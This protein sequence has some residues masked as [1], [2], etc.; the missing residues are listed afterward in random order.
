M[1]TVA[2]EQ[3]VVRR[4]RWSAHLW[5]LPL[6]LLAIILLGPVL[7]MVSTSL[8]QPGTEFAYPPVPLPQ[9]VVWRNYLDA[10]AQQPFGR[11]LANTLIIAG[12][13]TLGTVVSASLAAF[14]FA[15]IRFPGRDL[16]FVLLL[17]T[18]MLPDVVTLVPRY[19]LFS[20][21]HWINTFLPLTVPPW[22]GGGA[23]NVFLIRQF[24]MG[25]PYELDEAARM[26]GANNLQIYRQILLP[27]AGPALA[28]VAIFTVVANWNDF[29]SPLIYLNTP[30]R[31]TL[32]LGLQNYQTLYG[33]Q[34]AWLMAAA[35]VMVAPVVALFFAFQRFFV[36]GI[37]VTGLAGR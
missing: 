25:I 7:W 13:T 1:S 6:A 4:G 19:I 15:R 8:K 34:W 11:Y 20:K 14:G 9:P 16:L 28:T 22:F 2:V 27:L 3:V 23:F 12:T 5:Y 17:S 24:F 36:Q 37:Q 29:L 21:L 18:M 26:D 32:A 33:V 35:M 30:D 31:F 10:L